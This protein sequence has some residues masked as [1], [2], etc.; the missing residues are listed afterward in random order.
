MFVCLLYNDENDV[1][2]DVECEYGGVD[3][4]WVKFMDI[5]IKLWIFF[6]YFLLFLIYRVG[7]GDEKGGENA[8]EGEYDKEGEYGGKDD[9][10]VS[11]KV[12]FYFFYFSSKF[13]IFYFF[14]VDMKVIVKHQ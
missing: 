6:G 2:N 13:F 3:K 8:E 14:Y 4:V 10:K 7:Y 1:G 9:I 5:F 12:Y 11:L